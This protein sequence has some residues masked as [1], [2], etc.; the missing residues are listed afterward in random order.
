M[1]INIQKKMSVRLDLKFKY[2][3]WFYYKTRNSSKATVKQDTQLCL[4]YF[5]IV[6]NCNL[7]NC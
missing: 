2:M 3:E 5:K 6:T 4:R 1:E 7:L